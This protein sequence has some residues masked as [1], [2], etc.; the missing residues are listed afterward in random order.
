VTA[1]RLV[2]ADDH[3]QVLGEGFYV[4]ENLKHAETLA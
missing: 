2:I 3:E 4:Y 1:G